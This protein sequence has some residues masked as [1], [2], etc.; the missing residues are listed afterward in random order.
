MSITFA[1]R[2]PEKGK[3]KQPS[4][5]VQRQLVSLK[6]QTSTEWSP[7]L[8]K[9]TLCAEL[10]TPLSPQ[11]SIWPLGS[12]LSTGGI[13]DDLSGSN[14]VSCFI[15]LQLVSPVI[16]RHASLLILMALFGKTCHC[17]LPT[18]ASYKG[19][20]ANDDVCAEIRQ[21]IGPCPLLPHTKAMLP[22]MTSVPRSSRQ[23]GHAKTWPS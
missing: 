7:G 3:W 6:W 8:E 5:S 13:H 2:K 19:H 22:T 10:Y 17:R 18:A 4:F 15:W 23:S 20:V 21:A 9:V 1:D 12:A 16:S 14:I 11:T